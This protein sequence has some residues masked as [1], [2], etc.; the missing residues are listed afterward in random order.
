[1]ATHVE[2]KGG[3][4]LGG[5][6]P[7]Y[8]RARREERVALVR[9]VEYTPFPRVAVHQRGR[10]AFTRDVS[11]S[12]LCLRVD[13][14]EPVGSLLRVAVRGVDGRPARVAVARVV[15]TRP[16]VDG[17]H[18]LGLSIVEECARRVLRAPRTAS[19]LLAAR[20]RA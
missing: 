8:A 10:V 20:R 4:E 15:W 11:A 1:M 16:T 17:A 19:P 3:W 12:G 13:A 9:H 2:V 18:W 7:P 6:Q 5:A 14:P